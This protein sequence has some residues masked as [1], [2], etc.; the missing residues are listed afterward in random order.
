MPRIGTLAL[1][2]GLCCLGITAASAQGD[3][4]IMN[5]IAQKVVQKYQTS[6]CQQ[7]AAERGQRPSGMQGQVEQRV[8]RLLRQ[9]PQMRQAFL[10]KVAAPIANKLFECGIIP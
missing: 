10:N 7:L 6:S 5:R 2:A 8:I 4:P 1:V 9:D 3:Y